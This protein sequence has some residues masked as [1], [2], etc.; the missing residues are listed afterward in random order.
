MEP[1]LFVL[2]LMYQACLPLF[3]FQLGHLAFLYWSWLLLGLDI[4]EG[5]LSHI[6]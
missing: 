1:C 5:N 4:S 2:D 3:R 6:G